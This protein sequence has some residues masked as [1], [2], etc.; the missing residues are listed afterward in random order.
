MCADVPSSVCERPHAF[1][2][3]H[4]L[5][6][7]CLAVLRGAVFPVLLAGVSPCVPTHAAPSKTASAV[8]V[9]ARRL[10][11]T[12]CAASIAARTQARARR[13]ARAWPCWVADRAPRPPRLWSI[14]R[15]ARDRNY[16]KARATS[17]L[18]SPKTHMM[19]IFHQLVGAASIVPLAALPLPAGFGHAR[20]VHL[21]TSASRANLTHR[22]DTSRAELA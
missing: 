21:S 1:Q 11:A 13:R 3:V 22:D 14:W 17:L 12:Q 18:V 9:C 16:V 7:L 20:L 5:A 4:A 2:Q 19:P 8:P 6:T 10:M 15:C